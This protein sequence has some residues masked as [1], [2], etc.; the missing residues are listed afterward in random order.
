MRFCHTQIS[1][2]FT[3]CTHSFAFRTK[4]NIFAD[5]I[6]KSSA[7]PRIWSYLALQPQSLSSLLLEFY[8]P[9]LLDLHCLSWSMLFQ[10][11]TFLY[12]FFLLGVLLKWA[13]HMS[14]SGLWSRT[15]SF[16]RVVLTSGLGPA[17]FCTFPMKIFTIP[18]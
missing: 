16:K 18:F 15:A 2:H 4:P 11:L 13:T 12:Q 14:S 1:C 10:L 7:S 6:K 8:I 5:K 17:D 3:E 9:A